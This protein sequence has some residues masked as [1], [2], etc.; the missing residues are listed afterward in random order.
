MVP[1]IVLLGIVNCTPDS[2][3]DGVGYLFDPQTGDR[4][5]SS[6]LFC[7][8]A[9]A[10][11]DQG[12]E[13]IEVGGDSTRP[14]SFC[15]EDEEEWLRISPV[16]S[17]FAGKLPVSVD[18]H[19]A[20]IARR[21]IDSGAFMI[22][23]ITGGNQNELLEVV[24]KS[25]VLY[26]Y[27]FNAYGAAHIFTQTAMPLRVETCISTLSLWA[28]QKAKTISE[29]GIP[30]E[31]QI[32]DPGMGGFLSPDADVSRTV[33]ERFW[34]IQSPISQRM[35]GCSRKGFLRQK[36]E[37]S[38]LDRDL[39]SAHLG[40]RVSASTPPGSTL[41]LRIHNVSLHRRLLDQLRAQHSV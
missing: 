21:A 14:G 1:R 6:D 15:T 12:A 2:F 18:T 32:L 23:D 9:Q 13:M 29:Y 38:I 34:E 39:P 16:I 10:L 20:E 17:R 3:S 27:M 11:I 8:R 33:A 37:L 40:M 7:E 28:Q 25:Q 35:L 22:N 19:K 36:N 30:F 5:H 4:S 31:R 26:T 41:F 24:A